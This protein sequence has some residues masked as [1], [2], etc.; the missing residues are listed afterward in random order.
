M[1]LFRLTAA[2]D[3]SSVRDI[4]LQDRTEFDEA[5]IG[6]ENVRFIY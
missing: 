1:D 3:T 5:S 2:T 6:K 4:G